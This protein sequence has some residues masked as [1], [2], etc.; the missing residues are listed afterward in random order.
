MNSQLSVTSKVQSPKILNS[1]WT[2]K[3]IKNNGLIKNL[4]SSPILSPE[5]GLKQKIH[6]IQW[7]KP[8]LLSPVKPPYLRI[9]MS[10]SAMPIRSKS[11]VV[12]SQYISTT[13]Q[14]TS[15]G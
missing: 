3:P 2:V 14:E 4:K 10:V 6:I 5:A 11:S 13:N 9:G 7:V 8:F 12:A 15:Y 1:V